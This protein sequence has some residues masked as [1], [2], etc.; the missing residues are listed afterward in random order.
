M[1]TL[2]RVGPTR[3]SPQPKKFRAPRVPFFKS[4]GS[5]HPEPRAK[6]LHPLDSRSLSRH[7]VRSPRVL[8]GIEENNKR[9][10]RSITLLAPH[11]LNHLCAQTNEPS[12][13]RPERTALAGTD[14]SQR[15]HRCCR[16]LY[17]PVLAR[18]NICSPGRRSNRGWSSFIFNSVH[19]PNWN[20]GRHSGWRR[21]QKEIK[22][23]G[24]RHFSDAD[25]TEKRPSHDEANTRITGIHRPGCILLMA[26]L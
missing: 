3:R 20:R 22:F 1:Y 16:G 21:F 6:G 14:Y 13:K 24:T 8:P 9:E 11:L 25:D 26:P 19:N 17:D 5:R 12:A 15:V 23:A 4:R 2:R 10:K 7:F 18:A